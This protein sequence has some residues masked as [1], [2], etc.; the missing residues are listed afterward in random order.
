MPLKGEDIP[1]RVD[2]NIS[3]R[4]G[5]ERPAGIS[6]PM[7]S[8]GIFLRRNHSP[9]E[10]I[11]ILHYALFTP[12]P[13]KKITP[14]E[15]HRTWRESIFQNNSVRVNGPARFRVETTEIIFGIYWKSQ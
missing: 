12:K 14:L 5:L 8:Y 15:S 7:R 6:M 3:R 1:G 13:S 9:I 11:S 4:G 2:I 10:I